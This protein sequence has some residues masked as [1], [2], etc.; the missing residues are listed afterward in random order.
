M[1]R[2]NNSK[3]YF[4]EYLNIVNRKGDYWDEEI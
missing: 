4:Q 1:E 2:Y 3:K